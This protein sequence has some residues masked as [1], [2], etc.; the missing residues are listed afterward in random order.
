MAEV[1]EIIERYERRKHI[2]P[3]LYSRFNVEVLASTQERQRALVYLLRK[4][5]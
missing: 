1:D 3:N 4:A 5:A 2:G